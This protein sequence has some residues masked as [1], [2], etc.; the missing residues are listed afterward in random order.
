MPYSQKHIK[1]ISP[2][3]QQL[4]ISQISKVLE[5][6]NNNDYDAAWLCL[7]DLILICPPKVQ[8]F[9]DGL[10]DK[11]ILEEVQ[12]ITFRLKQIPTSKV[13]N[14][15]FSSMLGKRRICSSVLRNRLKPLLG[16]IMNLLY[17][18]GYLESEGLKPKYPSEQTLRWEE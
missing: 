16:K 9:K 13:G 12:S 6:L 18:G 1:P 17:Q 5:A 14:D 8:N 3:L 2:I 10:E 7:D 11:S 4:L 15:F